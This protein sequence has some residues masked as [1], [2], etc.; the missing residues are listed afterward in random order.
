MWRDNLKFWYALLFATPLKVKWKL[1]PEFE[2]QLNE[3]HRFDQ[4]NSTLVL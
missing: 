2:N 1:F 3:C 4:V